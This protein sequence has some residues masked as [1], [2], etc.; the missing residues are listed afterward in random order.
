[1]S[2]SDMLN[3]ILGRIEEEAKEA[4]TLPAKKTQLTGASKKKQTKREATCKLRKTLFKK[5]AQ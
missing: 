2:A 1:M 5:T 3:D 4:T